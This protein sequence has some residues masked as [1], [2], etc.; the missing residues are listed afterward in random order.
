MPGVQK[1]HC[2][3]WQCANPCWTGSSCPCRCRPSTVITWRPSAIAASTGQ[4][5]PGVWSSQTTQAPQFDVSPPQC[6]PVRPSSSL[7]RWMSSSRGSITLVYSVPLT[8]SA[9]CT[10][11]PCSRGLLAHGGS[12]QAGSLG[13]AAQRPHGELIGEVALVLGWPALVRDGLAVLGRDL[14]GPGEALGRG[15]CA[16]QEFLG[17]PRREVP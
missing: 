11:S 13:R 16:A 15:G 7:I 10:A 3:P 17:L 8:V 5:F 12:P 14:A 2:S 6:E 1:P 9:I 4:D